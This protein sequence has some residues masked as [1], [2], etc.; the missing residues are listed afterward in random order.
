MLNLFKASF[1]LH[2]FTN[3]SKRNICSI[4][5]KNLKNML[6]S[7]KLEFFMEAHNGM[8]ARIVQ[9]TGFKGIWAS[10][11]TMSASNG[12][13]DNN[14]MS[15]TQ[16]LDSVEYMSDAV[17]I[18]I[19]LD[20][21][22]GYGNFNNAR[23]L[24]T[25]LEQ[26]NI[27]GVC[28]EDKIFP[29]TNS[30]IDGETQE[31]ANI[32]EFCGK[33]QA[34]KDVQTDPDFCVVARLES[35]IVGNGIEDALKRAEAYE[36][37]G[38]DAILV[39]SKR[40]DDKDIEEFMKR[41]KV[42]KPIIIVPTTY[43]SVPTKKFQD[44]GISSI[45]WANFNM[46]ASM[47]AIEETSKNIYEN[48][49]VNQVID[50]VK[51]VKD[52]F[53]I[54]NVKELKQ[55]EN[56]YLNYIQKRR[57]STRIER[58]VNTE[59]FFDHLKNK[60]DFFAGVPDSLMKNLIT[61]INEKSDNITCANEGLAL[62]LSAGYNLATKKIP[63][64]YF[65]N[66][67]L[68]N[69]INPLLSLN[70]ENV[71]NI[72]ALFLVGWRG[73]PNTKDEPQHFK[74]GQK[75]IPLL[76]TCDVKSVVLS[77][78]TDEAIIQIDKAYEY[79]NKTQK[80]Y[81]I[82]ISADT[83]SEYKSKN[84]PINKSEL[85][86][87]IVINN[88]LNM[89]DNKDSLFISSTGYISRT[90]YNKKSN[91]KNVFYMVGSMGHCSQL[92]LGMAL[93]SDKKIICLDGDGSFLM[94]MGSLTTIGHFQPKNLIH[95]VFNNGIHNSVGKQP[96]LFK[97]SNLNKIAEYSGYKKVYKIINEK[98]LIN[99]LKKVSNE[100]GPILIEIEINSETNN[101]PR[102]QNFI[103]IKNNFNNNL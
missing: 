8:S 44:M 16:V 27:S 51:T 63:C 77:S 1:R 12:L 2:R 5:S 30:F 61:I 80:P 40:S 68:G 70:D 58:K 82:V 25:K 6:N 98:E 13:R 92:S 66:S 10:G 36:E 11:L 83:L 17:D 54:Q 46:R 24:I 19:L 56:K 101:L 67:G 78:N 65:Q 97:N 49:S 22:T 33:I 74:I 23:K 96:I 55:A 53:E 94:H 69:L 4:K 43:S 84:N 81:A 7:N 64:V 99:V 76:D 89:L 71:Y 103:N 85:N 87:D 90:L 93:Y 20:G 39:H 86:Y 34:C 102:V 26:R 50:Q 88:I 60:I 41:T 47:K 45:I 14:E 59:I 31:L 75:T 15:W 3:I 35:F 73:E 57:H 28:F 29:K 42:K 62:S 100:D 38:A 18:P 91:D 32:N 72:P 9:N 52:I 95:V 48:Q 79:I 21:D 37:A